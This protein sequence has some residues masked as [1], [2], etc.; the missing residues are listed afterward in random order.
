MT[1][2]RLA[3]LFPKEMQFR[4]AKWLS[5]FSP[6]FLTAERGKLKIV[7]RKK[8]SPKY[9]PYDLDKAGIYPFLAFSEEL[10]AQVLENFFKK[11][12]VREQL[13][14]IGIWLGKSGSIA[15]QITTAPR[16]RESDLDYLRVKY[17]IGK[18]R[19]DWRDI[20]FAGD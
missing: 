4:F 20:D 10:S 9:R 17:Y 2:Y 5:S 6:V 18:F 8:D 16:Q 11:G 7:L 1:L 15:R 19:F 3:D 12:G 14:T 13:A